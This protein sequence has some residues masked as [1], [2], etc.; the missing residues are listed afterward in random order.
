MSWTWSNERLWNRLE[1]NI[2]CQMFRPRRQIFVTSSRLL[3]FANYRRGLYKPRLIHVPVVQPDRF[4]SSV[5]EN[6][7]DV[8]KIMNDLYSPIEDT[9]SGFA[10]K[11]AIKENH[12]AISVSRTSV[13]VRSV[14]ARQCVLWSDSSLWPCTDSSLSV[15]GVVSVSSYI[16]RHLKRQLLCYLAVLTV[17]HCWH[18]STTRSYIVLYLRSWIDVCARPWTS[19]NLPDFTVVG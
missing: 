13:W 8:K 9:N 2:I 4:S 18:L 11:R 1:L 12:Q 5:L 16:L 10:V 19:L 3:S 17:T 6:I 7:V 14:V 15:R